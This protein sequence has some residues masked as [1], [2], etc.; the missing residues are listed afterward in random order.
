MT[1]A[2]IG[3]LLHA[4]AFLYLKCGATASA[5]T[6]GKVPMIYKSRVGVHPSHFRINFPSNSRSDKLSIVPSIIDVRASLG[7]D[8]L[9]EK[10]RCAISLL[11]AQQSRLA[12]S[13]QK[14]KL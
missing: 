5:K 13:W 11:K 2:L 6:S 8:I 4:S 9:I 14:L 1:T 7:S 3:A 12:L 10:N